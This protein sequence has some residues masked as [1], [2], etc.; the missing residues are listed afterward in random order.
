MC[1]D[2]KIIRAGELRTAS[3]PSSFTPPSS[4]WNVLS[5]ELKFRRDFCSQCVNTVSSSYFQAQH[6]KQGTGAPSK[7]G[8]GTAWAEWHIAVPDKGLQQ[9]FTSSFPLRHR[10]LLCGSL[11]ALWQISSWCDSVHKLHFI[12]KGEAETC[13][14]QGSPSL[15]GLHCRVSL[16]QLILHFIFIDQLLYLNLSVYNLQRWWQSKKLILS[17]QPFTSL[18]YCYIFPPQELI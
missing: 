6:H 13:W 7:Q 16:M 18:P 2:R 9:H 10:P 15:A 17:V 4:P 1:L 5:V 3:C 8:A 12:I 11:S 14:E